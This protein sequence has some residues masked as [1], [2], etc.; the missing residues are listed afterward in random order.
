MRLY[1]WVLGLLALVSA[2]CELLLLLTAG[3][4]AVGTIGHQIGMEIGRGLFIFLIAAL[5]ATIFAVATRGQ[6]DPHAGLVAGTTYALG[7]TAYMF[8]GLLKVPF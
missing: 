4:L 6:N 7:V 2:A 5:V 8:F 3:P 1:L